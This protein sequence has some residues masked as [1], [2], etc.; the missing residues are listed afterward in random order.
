MI[1]C[2]NN[3]QCVYLTKTAYI[4]SLIGISSSTES[5]RSQS[6]VVSG[7]F[8]SGSGGMGQVGLGK[9]LKFMGWVG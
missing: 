1:M 9:E 8:R 2:Y 5:G 3:T 4:N 7:G 6:H